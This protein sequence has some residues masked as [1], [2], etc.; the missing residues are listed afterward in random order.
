ML[1]KTITYTDYDGVE[2]TEDFF[3]NISRA[4]L[5]MMDHEIVGGMKGKLEKIIQSK[6][7]VAIMDMFKDIIHRSYG[8]KSDD[9]KRFIKSEE[10][11][12]AFEQS[13]A[14]SEFLVE[15]FSDPDIAA[16]FIRNVFPKEYVDSSPHLVPG[17]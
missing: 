5:I 8:T 12:L 9:G 13:E 1:K 4:E 3:F 17:A 10:N 2:R 11:T 14:F 16:N 6:D 7:N 15:L